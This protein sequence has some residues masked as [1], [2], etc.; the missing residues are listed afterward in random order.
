MSPDADPLDRVLGPLDRPPTDGELLALERR[1]A[2]VD[3]RLAEAAARID[4][5]IT[6]ALRPASR[7]GAPHRDPADAMLVA[8]LRRVRVG[9]RGVDAQA[10]RL[11]EQIQ[12]RLQ[13]MLDAV[14]YAARIETA[15][16]GRVRAATAIGWGGDSASVVDPAL[17]PETLAVH[18]RRVAVSIAQRRGRVRFVALVLGGVARIAAAFAGGGLGALPALYRYV[19]QVLDAFDTLADAEAAALPAG[20]DP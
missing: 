9:S 3:A 20:A 15:A 7:G 12:A 11:V 8:D 2:E 5:A 10:Q 16:G 6:A 1:A 4:D 18:R 17:D 19:E 13:G 14:R